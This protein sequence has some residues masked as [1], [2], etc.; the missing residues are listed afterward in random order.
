MLVHSKQCGT[1][2]MAMITQTGKA[3]IFMFKW[4]LKIVIDMSLLGYYPFLRL[5]NTAEESSF[6]CY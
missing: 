2:V 3:V 1:F 5:F 6:K 4:S